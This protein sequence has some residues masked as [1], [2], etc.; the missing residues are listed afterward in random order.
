MIF[1]LLFLED[2][3]YLNGKLCE[4]RLKPLDSLG[5]IVVPIRALALKSQVVL[6]LTLDPPPIVIVTLGKWFP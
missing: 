5:S 2:F 6:T 3:A 4:L 1:R